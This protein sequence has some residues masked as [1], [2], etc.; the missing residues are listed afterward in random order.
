MGQAGSQHHV[1]AVQPDDYQSFVKA[2]KKADAELKDGYEISSPSLEAY[3]K[4]IAPLGA[5]NDTM[6]I[7]M[8][9]LWVAGGLLLVASA[10]SDG[11]RRR[12]EIGYALT[13]GVSKAR[14]GWQFMLEVWMVTL[15]AF[16]NPRRWPADSPPDRWVPRSADGHAPPAMTADVVWTM[17]GAGLGCCLALALVAMLRVAAFSA[18]RWLIPVRR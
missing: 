8:I 11:L 3:H 1:H 14:L 15:P 13:V 2:A 5:L 17:V 16:A 6:R 9:A 10:G 4:S 7:T 12:E 18:S